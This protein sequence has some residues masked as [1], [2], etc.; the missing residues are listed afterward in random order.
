MARIGT[1]LRYCICRHRFRA[2]WDERHD[3]RSC[4][5][6][7]F[8]YVSRCPL[9]MR[10]R[11]LVPYNWNWTRWRYRT[12][13]GKT[14][15]WDQW[16]PESGC[17]PSGLHRSRCTPYWGLWIFLPSKGISFFV[18]F[19]LISG[20]FRELFCRPS[21][22]RISHYLALSKPDTHTLNLSSKLSRTPTNATPPQA[23]PPIPSINHWQFIANE[24]N[25]V[26]FGDKLD[27]SQIRERVHALSICCKQLGKF[28]FSDASQTNC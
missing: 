22:A 5:S 19:G 4:F 26:F 18:F 3:D 15:I 25:S 13:G 2:P 12:V 7:V 16:P 23:G 21:H 28:F 8:F 6:F 27:I 14:K 11:S 9:P 10:S 20:I 1:A 17:H 24:I